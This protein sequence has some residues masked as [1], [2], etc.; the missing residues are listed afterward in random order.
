M[1]T[2][3]NW[4]V[5]LLASSYVPQSN[6]QK[7]A[8]TICVGYFGDEQADQNPR[9]VT[10]AGY[11]ASK[12]RWRMFDQRWPR[13]LRAER[14]T[15]FNADQFL[16]G[17]G[18]FASGWTDDPPRQVRLIRTLTR[19]A[20]QHVLR[21]FAC[22][23]SLGE[24]DAVNAEYC[25]AERVSG[26]YG[27][28]AAGLI[29]SVQRWMGEHHPADLTLFV[30]EEGD[31][32]QREIRRVLGAEGVATGEP[33]QVWPRQWTDELGRRRLLRPFEA[34]DLM[35]LGTLRPAH[36]ADVIDR[37]RLLKICRALAVQRR[38]EPEPVSR[39]ARWRVNHGRQGPRG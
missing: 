36:Q 26:P 21:G 33:P 4:P 18:E 7:L 28:C 35:A 20:E 27:L 30:F 31:V 3:A 25:L 16:R 38:F 15:A 6:P 24:F 11:V 14:L 5:A 29:A 23:L 12:A 17:F 34:C 2:T 39:P 37:E 22:S 8:M 19:V 9:T 32:E 13:V 10:V 1:T